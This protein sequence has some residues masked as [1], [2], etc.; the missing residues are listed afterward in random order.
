M[1][2]DVVAA[3]LA[4]AEGRAVVAAEAG[5]LDSVAAVGVVAVAVAVAAGAA[6]VVVAV[7]AAGGRGP[8]Q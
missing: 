7:W 5:I 4:P 2:P 1:E 8:S 6:V 3:A